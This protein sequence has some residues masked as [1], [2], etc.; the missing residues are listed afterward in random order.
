MRAADSAT[1]RRE[2]ADADKPAPGTSPLGGPNRT[3]KL[4][5]TVGSRRGGNKT[6]P[7]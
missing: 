6:P 2:V 3:L 7:H 4:A 5:G 1:K